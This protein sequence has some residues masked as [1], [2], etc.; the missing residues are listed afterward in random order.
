MVAVPLYPSRNAIRSW[1]IRRSRRRA[2]HAGCRLELD[3]VGVV[4]DAIE[5]GV[6]RH[7]VADDLVCSAHNLL[8]IDLPKQLR[9]LLALVDY[10]V[11]I[12][13]LRRILRASIQLRTFRPIVPVPLS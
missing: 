12:L 1:L 5:D 6:G 9:E 7:R 13:S 4:D 3:P 11:S 2:A 8:L 10:A